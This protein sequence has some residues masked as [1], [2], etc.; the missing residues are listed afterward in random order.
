M[1]LSVNR[2]VWQYMLLIAIVLVLVISF[3][4]YIKPI[5]IALVLG[6][7]V[8]VLADKVVDAFRRATAH[9]SSRKRAAIAVTCSATVVLVVG[10]FLIAGAL[11]LFNNFNATVDFFTDF[12]NQ[13]NESAESLAKDLANITTDDSLASY[14]FTSE[15]R[16]PGGGTMSSEMPDGPPAE[17][18][19]LA[20]LS[21]NESGQST[22]GVLSSFL[23]SGSGIM[24]MT[25][26]TISMLTT[27][28]FASCLLIP[29]MVIYHF[30]EKKRM[31]DRILERVPVK[32]KDIMDKTLKNIT[33][34][35][36]AFTIAKITEAAFITFL[37]C[38]GFYI[39]GLPHWLLAGVLIGTFNII[40]YIGFTIPA[41][42]VSVY[43]Y[44]L[45]IEVMFATVGI[46]VLIQLFDY[47][48]LLPN[49]VMKTVKISSFTSVI[50]TLAGL[51]LFGFFGLIFA[52]PI[53]IFCKITMVAAYK[54][55]ITM[56]PDPADQD[57][58]NSSDS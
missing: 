32:Y 54:M 44:T 40:P 24:D 8:T 47:F 5:F 35:M 12:N 18:I 17:P 53:Y 46:I 58:I 21:G 14:I 3:L 42:P 10:I 27:I 38:A 1:G 51:K 26:G 9:H 45:G 23:L 29:I 16:T 49:M 4:F 37:Y 50:L 56:Y 31:R 25:V 15:D 33:S 41:I 11:A 19:G 43:A 2:K 30:K 34:D 48:F 13:Y 36:S 57:E 7:L 6:L 55:L 28:F 52:V 20:G 22:A 39:I